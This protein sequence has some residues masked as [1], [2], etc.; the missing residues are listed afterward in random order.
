MISAHFVP[1]E[2]THDVLT[3][4]NWEPTTLA[5]L[6]LI[7]GL[8]AVGLARSAGRRGNLFP[9]WRPL[10]FYTGLLVMFLALI[11][12]IDALSE[13]LFL[14]HMIQH[15][16]LTM[17]AV[18]LLLLGA[19][20]IPV[21]RGLPRPFRRSVL[22][23]VARN[24]KVRTLLAFLTKARIAF[25]L[26][27]GATWLWHMPF[28]YDFAL[29]NE[30]AHVSEHGIFIGTAALFW[31]VV[32]E[33]VPFKLRKSYAMRMLYLFGAATPN[34][35]LGAFLTYS[36]RP[37]YNFYIDQT[38]LWGF[39][40]SEDQTLGGVIMWLP[41]WMMF[42]MA[43][44]IVFFIMMSEEERRTEANSRAAMQSRHG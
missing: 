26:F 42:L 41:G 10:C 13:H 39:T 31:W 34:A 7:G 15:M 40:A 30:W 6:G 29:R 9:F 4:W 14:M 25:L 18:P 33:P 21:L 8:Y 28:M 3:A 5:S 17:W 2:T 37:W 38:Q 43:L 36:P 12:P 11:S 1:I 20:I 24:R 32:I 23:P 35:A 16:L 19:P 22:G 44:A 27:F